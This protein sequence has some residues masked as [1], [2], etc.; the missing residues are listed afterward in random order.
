MNKENS[1]HQKEKKE[2]LSLSKEEDNK[3][4]SPLS[5]KKDSSIN[6]LSPENTN[7]INQK[8]FPSKEN[9]FG[10]K[11]SPNKNNKKTL[12]P[13]N[14]SP[15]MNYFSGFSPENKDN[16]SSPK[17]GLSHQ[18]NNNNNP[19]KLS[20]LYFNYSPSTIFNAP[21]NKE[22]K[23]MVDFSLHNSGNY[24][25]DNKTLQEKIEQFD[26][27]NFIRINSNPSNSSNLQENKNEEDNEEEEDDD[28]NGVEALTL[29]ID[30]VEEDFLLGNNKS[31]LMNLNENNNYKKTT[32]F[33]NLEKNNKINNNIIFDKYN[34]INNNNYNI[35]NND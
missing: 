28:D 5:S 3:D 17:E 1:N 10:V 7:F 9:F 23:D 33:K 13:G 30:S 29:T 19:N 22:L 12:S 11:T 25:D 26:V 27:N 18:N 4:S 14:H 35:N 24:E 32:I 2:N 6:N 8:F 34:Y 20:P 31:K 15:I 16:S 21:K